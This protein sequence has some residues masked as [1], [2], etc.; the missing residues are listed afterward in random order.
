MYLFMWDISLTV[1]A[2]DLPES[3]DGYSRSLVS[4]V[5]VSSIVIPLEV[6]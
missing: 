4:L 6:T 5:M 2:L 1:I 3:S